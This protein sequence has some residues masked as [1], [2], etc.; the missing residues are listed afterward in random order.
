MMKKLSIAGSLVGGI[1]ETQDCIDFCH[2]QI[3][4]PKIK[5]VSSND[6]DSVFKLLHGKN[7]SITR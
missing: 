4:V 1:P 7:D 6:L 2:K 3:I 5:L